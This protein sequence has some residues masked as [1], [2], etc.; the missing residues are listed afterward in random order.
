MTSVARQT[1]WTDYN[2]K[3]PAREFSRGLRMILLLHRNRMKSFSLGLQR[4]SY[5]HGKFVNVNPHS[6]VVEIFMGCS[7]HSFFRV[8]KIKFS[9]CRVI[10][11]LNFMQT[12]NHIAPGAPGIAPRW[13]S[14]AKHGVGTAYHSSSRVWF[15]LSHGCLLYT[16]RCV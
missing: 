5:L 16:S 4:T 10:Q 14:S 12:S 9:V 6:S 8:Q 1:F 3:I 7:P 15:T 11:K 2:C 13:A